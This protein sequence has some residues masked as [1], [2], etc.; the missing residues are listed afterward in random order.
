MTDTF[1]VF[2]LIVKYLLLCSG[3]CGIYYFAYMEDK[4]VNQ[5]V[6][7]F[8]VTVQN[9][10]QQIQIHHAG[11]Q[12]LQLLHGVVVHQCSVIGDAIVRDAK[13]GHELASGLVQN[14]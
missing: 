10:A 7:E 9:E 5:I 2:Q 12:L 13:F 1:V 6:I 11:R 8:L 4:G 14:R 3:F